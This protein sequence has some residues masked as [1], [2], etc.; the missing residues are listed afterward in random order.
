MKVICIIPARFN[1]KRFPGKI[2]AIIDGKPMIQRVY[3]QAVKAKRIDRVIVATDDERIMEAVKGFGG[4]PVMT[5]ECRSGTDR[6]AVVVEELNTDI[7]VNVQG[8]EPLLPTEVIDG[9]AGL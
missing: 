2:L 8:D 6:V 5:P 4:E 9:T 3:E 1:S 7:I